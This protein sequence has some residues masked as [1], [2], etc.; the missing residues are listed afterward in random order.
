[1]PE[2]GPLDERR[3]TTAEWVLAWLQDAETMVRGLIVSYEV[4]TAL[5]AI[6]LSDT[7]LS[8]ES[9]S[10]PSTDPGGRRAEDL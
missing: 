4:P 10:A 8:S 5:D 3:K 6:P 2:L 1:M 7:T 9:P